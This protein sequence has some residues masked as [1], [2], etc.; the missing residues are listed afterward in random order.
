MITSWDI[1]FALTSTILNDVS[2]I[3]DVGSLA[4]SKKPIS[5]FIC[6]LHVRQRIVT[7]H[8]PREQV[9]S[10]WGLKRRRN[11]VSNFK[12]LACNYRHT[13]HASY[14]LSHARGLNPLTHTHTHTLVKRLFSPLISCDLI[15]KGKL[16]HKSQLTV[17]FCPTH[18]LAVCL[19][20]D[21]EENLQIICTR[22]I[23]SHWSACE[24]KSFLLFVQKGPRF[25]IV[26]F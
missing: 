18:E 2:M 9:I 24:P 7:Y 16:H 11:K 23:T 13:S 21:R 22:S 1:T 12:I 8:S 14:Q 19:I 10:S 26:P 20:C 3:L 17:N 4:S 5:S 25:P 6:R 15:T